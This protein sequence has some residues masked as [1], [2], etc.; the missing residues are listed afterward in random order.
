MKTLLLILALFVFSSVNAQIYYY[1]S[2]SPADPANWNTQLN[3]SGSPAINFS[4]PTNYIIPTGKTATVS[5]TWIFGAAGTT[6][7]V[8]A[9][10][11]LQNNGEV[12]MHGSSILALDSGSLYVNNNL[13]FASITIFNGTELFNKYST[14]RID[15]WSSILQVVYAGVSTN[16]ANYYFGNL[17]INWNMPNP[18]RWA[19]NMTGVSPAI[20][21][22]NFK[23]TNIG[24]GYF[25]FHNY[26]SG[27]P[28]VVNIKG[29]YIQEQGNVY[30][31]NNAGNNSTID[32]YLQIEGNFIRNGGELLTTGNSRGDVR[33]VKMATPSDT[34]Y[35]TF[36]S[37]ASLHGAIKYSV[38]GD[39][40]LRLKSNFFMPSAIPNSGLDVF[41]SLNSTY[42]G[43]DMQNYEVGG[44]TPLLIEGRVLVSLRS[45]FGYKNGAHE[46]NITTD[47]PVFI[48]TQAKLLF[49]GSGPQITGVLAP[50]YI[51]NIE[52]VNPDGVT[53]SKNL[54][55][56]T[57]NLASKLNLSDYNLTV[58]D[59]SAITGVTLN[60][61]IN[62]NGT[63]SLKSYIS[64][65]AKIIPIGNGTFN[66]VRIVPVTGNVPDTFAFRVKDGF[67]PAMLPSDTSYCI[68]KTWDIVEKNLGGSLMY[69]LFQWRRTDE[70]VN[71]NRS[72]NAYSGAVGVYN[73]ETYNGYR[74]FRANT[75][76]LPF[77]ATSDTGIAYS[78]TLY[79]VS[80]LFYEFGSNNK[81]VVGLE[82]GI[83]E[84][85]YYNSGNAATLNAWKKNQ[86]GTGSSLQNFNRYQILNVTQNKNAVFN[87]SAV[88]G[89]LTQLR[90]SGNG[91]VTTNQPVTISG[92]FEM[93]DSATY[94]HNNIGIAR[95]TIF[96][97]SEY[98]GK[99][100]TVDIT[101]WSDTS[102]AI[103][104]GLGDV[105]GNLIINFTNL[106]DP[107]PNGRWRNSFPNPNILCYNLKYIQSSG[108]DFCPVGRY[109]E[110]VNFTMNIWENL[111][112]GDSII[113]PDANPVL[114]L[115]F[116]TSQ[117]SGSSAG[118]LNIGKNIDIQR[119]II[120]SEENIFS[121]NGRIAFTSFGSRRK[122]YISSYQ[123]ESTPVFNIGN[124][125]YPNTMNMEDT[126]VLRSN[127][128]NSQNSSF[129]P[130]D[131]FEILNTSVLDCDTFSFRGM[132]LRVKSGGKVIIRNKEGMN[133]DLGSLQNIIFE[134][135]A[136]LELAGNETQKLYKAGSTPIPLLSTLIINNPS[137]IILN[138]VVT[139][140][141]TL[142][143]IRGK[144]SSDLTYL[145]FTDTTGATG[146][147]NSAY[148]D[149]PVKLFT[150][151]IIPKWIP[152]GED[153]KLRSIN[154]Q[155]ASNTPAQWILGYNAVDPHTIGSI[156]GPGINNISSNE[157]YF[158]NN[159]TPGIGAY[160]GISY[161]PESG[162]TEIE[163]L[164]VAR[165]NGNLWENKGAINYLGNSNSGYIISDYCSDFNYFALSSINV[166][167][168][169]VELASFSGTA[170]GN[171][172]NLSW[173]TSY[174]LNNTGFDIERKSKSDTTWKKISFMN[175]TGNSNSQI[176]YK[177]EDRNLP[178]EK[179]NYRLKQIDNNGN[180]KYYTLQN[181]III[182]VPNKFELS[183]NYPNPFNP[184]TKINFNLPVDSKVQLSIY[185]ITGRLIATV[186]NNESFSAG[187]HTVQFN[188]SLLSSGTYF[189]RMT[190]GELVQT[191]KMTLVK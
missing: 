186:I 51:P 143:F 133:F 10:A 142:K 184:A 25:Q 169:P 80:G 73:A 43:F 46:G 95:N 75:F 58:S 77:S 137:G 28:A 101:M 172:V 94:N 162:V 145:Q 166:Q 121:A 11:I 128:Y 129:F 36:Y 93:N 191:K 85:Y 156:Y 45:P 158:V 190:A 189:Y 178:L 182:G 34:A 30:L 116:G 22:N 3:G 106:S 113:A 6:L 114:N 126:L 82:K 13:S 39:A 159:L 111:Q 98:F 110:G 175:G 149:A 66:P 29:D 52:I 17:E 33:F 99:N 151:S 127:F 37:P 160:V 70:G 120:K 87:S 153:G 63:G 81:F 171:N 103:R 26:S 64:T 72:N 117:V 50:D 90:L 59:P 24:N 132:N 69:V 152:V 168:L 18:E 161:G 78:A 89:S 9:G 136:M 150:K 112:L 148:I 109:D 97:G 7:R 2:G 187:Y 135:G 157:Y 96:A 164:R 88:L 61:F 38:M 40:G 84:H 68:R 154:F 44:W 147:S 123:P 67:Y 180:Y 102:N 79:G 188:G 140:T 125:S 181:E 19:Q 83:F 167:P 1:Q 12:Q 131:Y 185:D 130:S 155:A 183:Q 92:V 15:N 118:S 31:G 104:D 47:G 146:M 55:V 49:N 177:Y 170:S 144:V 107:G 35:Q 134:E 108:Y 20:C 165:W 119:G 74:P 138:E 42:T 57:V 173:N 56:Y 174:E 60:H 8:Y 65:D 179:Y 115:S 14:V 54:R 100:T 5:N 23:L 41:G 141:D 53:L 27:D 71:F 105:I 122:H 76:D 62:T 48:S 32:T 163:S 91:R 21:G 86:D 4:A 139:V 124:S 176:N 16:S